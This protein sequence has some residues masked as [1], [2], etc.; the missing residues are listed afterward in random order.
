[1]DLNDSI[2]YFIEPLVTSTQSLVG[3]IKI[4]FGGIFGLYIVLVILRWHEFRM[5]RHV[6][7]EIREEV[8]IIKESVKEIKR[9][10]NKVKKENNVR[11]S[12]K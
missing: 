9:V 8:K 12:K 3:F 4:I 1:M 5:L 6:T 10:E 11:K 7:S 2:L